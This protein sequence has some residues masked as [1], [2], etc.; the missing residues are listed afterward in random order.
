[1]T[2]VK[3]YERIDYFEIITE[4]KGVISKRLIQALLKQRNNLDRKSE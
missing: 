2:E 3:T 1:M 4:L